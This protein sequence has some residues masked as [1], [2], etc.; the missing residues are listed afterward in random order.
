M[1][2]S[3]KMLLT[4]LAI[5]LLLAILTSCK[6][7][8]Q[9]PAPPV[10]SPVVTGNAIKFTNRYPEYKC[11]GDG[12]NYTQYQNVLLFL[13][14]ADAIESNYAIA[15]KEFTR[16]IFQNEYQ[17]ED[18]DTGTYWYHSYTSRQWP[19]PCNGGYTVLQSVGKFTIYTD[20]IPVI[21]LP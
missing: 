12:N 10:A 3:Q 1:K 4:T 14:S 11:T 16:Q 19:N 9:Q 15:G 6:K 13:D 20:S 7:D 5:T 17:F 18:L 8:D 21:K 2:T